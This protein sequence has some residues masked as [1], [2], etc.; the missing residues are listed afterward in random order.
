VERTRELLDESVRLHLVSDVPVGV[1]LSG[2][3]DSSALVAL[4]AQ[5][6]THL[7]TLSIAFD[8]AAYDESRYAHLVAEKYATE[9]VEYRVT[10]RD[11]WDAL[12]RIFA[13]MD[14]PTVDGEWVI[15]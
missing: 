11:F 12:P 6:H 7:K 3:T 1:F 2:G 14:Q 8:E 10:A 4:A 9:H 13:A 5:H 15:R